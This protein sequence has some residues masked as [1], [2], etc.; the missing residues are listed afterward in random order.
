MQRFVAGSLDYLAGGIGVGMRTLAL[1]DLFAQLGA[2]CKSMTVRRR[3]MLAS[4]ATVTDWRPGPPAGI[5]LRRQRLQPDSKRGNA[6]G[7]S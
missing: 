7:F 3:P 4:S 2:G 1:L 5:A 6:F